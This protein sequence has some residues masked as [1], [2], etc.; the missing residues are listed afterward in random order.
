MASLSRRFEMERVLAQG[1][2]WKIT[3]NTFTDRVYLILTSAY[4]TVEFVP[5]DEKT[6][7][8]LESIEREHNKLVEQGPLMAESITE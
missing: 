2:T 7:G 6:L 4:G 8:I 3:H 1:D 5:K